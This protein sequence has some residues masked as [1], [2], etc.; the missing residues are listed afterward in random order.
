MMATYGSVSASH[1]NDKSS[2]KKQPSRGNNG[3][4]NVADSVDN[5]RKNKNFPHAALAAPPAENRRKYKLTK[6]EATDDI[7]KKK[8]AFM[9]LR[10]V[11]SAICVRNSSIRERAIRAL[12]GGR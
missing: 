11:A 10:T 8:C 4:H 1:S 7:A 6:R 2:K 9:S 12:W 5:K 3:E